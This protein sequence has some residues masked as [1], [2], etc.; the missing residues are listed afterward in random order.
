MLSIC[1]QYS[2]DSSIIQQNDHVICVE[3]LLGGE[4]EVVCG[5]DRDF[6][7]FIT[8]FE[9]D[10][11]TLQDFLHGE[12]FRCRKLDGCDFVNSKGCSVI[13]GQAEFGDEGGKEDL[14]FAGNDY[15]FVPVMEFNGICN[16][17]RAKA[18][19]FKGETINLTVPDIPLYI[20]NF[21]WL[22]INNMI[23]MYIRI[24]FNYGIFPIGHYNRIR[25]RDRHIVQ[26][27][28]SHEGFVNGDIDAFIACLNIG[29]CFVSASGL[30]SVFWCGG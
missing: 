19:S 3:G 18:V 7:G 30:G 17:V 11:V 16:H 14:A 28:F 15:F 24:A 20:F 27:V 4:E 5:F 22:I 26:P 25:E 23:E 12:E 13:A 1:N 21:S 10:N 6:R 29:Y 2:D 9:R 8:V